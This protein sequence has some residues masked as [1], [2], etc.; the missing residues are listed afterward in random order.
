MDFRRRVGKHVEFN[1][2]KFDTYPQE[3]F[4]RAVMAVSIQQF[5]QIVS[6]STPSISVTR[7]LTIIEMQIVRPLSLFF[8]I[9]FT[10]TVNG[11]RWKA[12]NAT[13]NSQSVG[14]P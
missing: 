13:S 7:F 2:I 12:V 4:T 6:G 9:F 10:P 1:D 8:H 11:L 5:C 3:S 14:F